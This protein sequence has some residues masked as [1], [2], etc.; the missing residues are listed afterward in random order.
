MLRPFR[1]LLAEANPTLAV[2]KPAALAVATF[3]VAAGFIGWG[4][5]RPDIPECRDVPRTV[6]RCWVG[7]RWIFT[8]VTGD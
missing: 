5:A 7:P 4:V 8:S 2:A 1:Y 6:E 3:L